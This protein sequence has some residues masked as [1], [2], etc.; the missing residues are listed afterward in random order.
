M[1]KRFLRKNGIKEKSLP[2]HDSAL[3]WQV[4]VIQESANEPR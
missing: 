1:S 3:H 2:V 4:L